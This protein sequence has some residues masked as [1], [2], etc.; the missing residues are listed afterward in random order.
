MRVEA[1]PGNE[2]RKGWP[3]LKASLLVLSA[4]SVY[5]V[6]KHTLWPN[7]SLWESHLLTIVFSTLCSIF[8]AYWVTDRLHRALKELAVQN[9]ENERLHKNLEDTLARLRETSEEVETLSGLLPVCAWCKKIRDDDGSWR[10]IEA[11]VT[12]KTHTRL[13]H[14]ICPECASKVEEEI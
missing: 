13:S 1:L 7:I 3:I 2:K 10:S 11:Y 5:E 4:M 6:L 8:A 12:R 9:V 14:G